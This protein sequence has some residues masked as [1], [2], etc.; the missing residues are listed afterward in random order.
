MNSI[1]TQLL[2]FL[3]TLHEHAHLTMFIHEHISVNK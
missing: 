1:N 2:P 3:S